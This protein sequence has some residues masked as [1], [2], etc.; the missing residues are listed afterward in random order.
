MFLLDLI[1]LVQY[2]IN[3][4]FD[5]CWQVQNRGLCVC[6]HTLPFD[7][8]SKIKHKSGGKKIEN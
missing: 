8:M 2:Y 3:F 1:Y 4:L 6:A 5:V 7:M